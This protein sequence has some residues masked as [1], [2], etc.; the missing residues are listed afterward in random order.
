MIQMILQYL[1]SILKAIGTTAETINI[2]Y[3]NKMPFKIEFRLGEVGGY[4]NFYLAPR[5]DDR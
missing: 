2:E 3:S 5:I 4:I 1:L